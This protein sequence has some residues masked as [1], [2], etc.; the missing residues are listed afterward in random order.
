[1]PGWVVSVLVA[2]VLVALGGAAYIFIRARSAPTAAAAPGVA[3]QSPSTAAGGVP[4]RLVKFI[5]IAGIRILEENKKS[6][7]RCLVVNHSPAELPEVRGTV[8]LR[9]P[10]GG[11]TAPLASFAFRVAGLGPW[12]SREVIAPLETRLRA[13]EVPDWQFLRAELQITSP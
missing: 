10:E 11:S 8:L 4:N 13:Y 9:A 1:M 7:V 3:M 2:L 6:Q 12:E 5:E